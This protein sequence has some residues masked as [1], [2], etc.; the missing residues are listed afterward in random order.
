MNDH[1]FTGPTAFC[2]WLLF[3]GQYEFLM[4]H[5]NNHTPTAF[6]AG[7]AVLSLTLGV[8]A[9]VTAEFLPV[10]ILP[11]VAAGFNITEG[12]AGMM[13]TVPGILAA[14]A[15]PGVMLAAGR[16]D[17]RSVLLFL[18]F[19]LLVSCGVAAWAPSFS[20]LL[21]SRAMVGLCLGAFWA[22][23]LAVAG[24]LTTPEKAHKA[25]AT[26]FAGVTAAMI[27]GVPFGTFTAGLF[28]W[29]GAFISTGLVSAAAFLMQLIALP[30]LPAGKGMKL[31]G[32][33]DYLKLQT[34]RKSKAL[35]F[36]IFG[37]HFATYTYLAPLLQQ[38]GISSDTV[39]WILVGYGIAGLASNF[40]AS[41]FI[42]RQLTATFTTV[43]MLLMV[44]LATLPQMTSW[45][46]GITLMV[47]VWGLAWG[48]MPLCM[49]IWNQRASS[50]HEEASS[51]MFTFTIQVAI[52]AGSA[53]GG[54]LV[55]TLG[56]PAGYHIAAAC[57]LVSALILLAYRPQNKAA[58]VE[59]R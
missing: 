9:T 58:K 53:A 41:A 13:I 15:A 39:T 52:A 55:D 51:A 18:S 27:L 12:Q 22:T 28:S 59:I 48:A 46:V 7:I 35:I 8:F 42:S 3:T 20:V 17:R 31:S 4:T 19:L 30:S 16:A 5:V 11:E 33:A 45:P 57:V 26:V 49:N 29:R 56:L 10:G 24:R 44:A 47:M 40:V 38:A 50:G 14:L 25:T 32:I 6:R 23:A 2:Q 54:K 43:L 1:S 21:I 34:A 37:A 36:L